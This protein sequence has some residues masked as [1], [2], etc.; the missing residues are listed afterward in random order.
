MKFTARGDASLLT[1][2]GSPQNNAQQPAAAPAASLRGL[3]GRGLP[4]FASLGAALMGGPAAAPPPPA[5]VV[6]RRTKTIF[7][8]DFCLTNGQHGCPIITGAG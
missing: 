3:L 7:P 2:G 4:A 6:E 1:C 5:E 8:G